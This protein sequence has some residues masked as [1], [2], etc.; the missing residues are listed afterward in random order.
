[1]RSNRWIALVAGALV[2]VPLLGSATVAEEGK[3][4]EA[5]V[6]EA[7][8]AEAG[9][10]ETKAEKAEVA[11][12]EGN[13]ARGVFTSAIVDREPQDE[14]ES[15]SNDVEKIIFFTELADLA[16][17]TVTHRWEYNGKVMAEVSFDVGADR[18]RTHSSKNLQPIWLGEWTVTVVD[19][20]ENVL[21]I[22]R[23]DYQAATAAVPAAPAE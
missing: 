7:E 23:F 21:S 19:A 9:V 11:E 13:V 5:V 3:V 4:A 18:W 22:H 8:V 2:A 6:E 16:G 14:L 17:Q 10:E 15:L 1:M 20:N 12:A